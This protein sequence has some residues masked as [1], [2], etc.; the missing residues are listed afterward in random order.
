MHIPNTHSHINYSIQSLHFSDKD[1]MSY[2]R[3]RIVTTLNNEMP[4]SLIFSLLRAA[5]MC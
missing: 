2:N 3:S 4:I 1:K 5:N